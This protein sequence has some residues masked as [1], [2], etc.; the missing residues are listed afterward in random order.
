MKLPALSRASLKFQPTKKYNLLSP[1]SF[2]KWRGN[3]WPGPRSSPPT[4]VTIW[5]LLSWPFHG[6]V[7]CHATWAAQ[8]KEGLPPRP[9]IIFLSFAFFFLTVFYLRCPRFMEPEFGPSKWSLLSVLRV[10]IRQFVSFNPSESWLNYPKSFSRFGSASRGQ[11]V[12]D[13][14]FL[15]THFCAERRYEGGRF[16]CEEDF[17]RKLRHVLGWC[18][19]A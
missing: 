13:L 9:R 2:P 8:I 12:W 7:F 5:W 15:Y 19:Q 17:K 14:R 1:D 11:R 3:F 16:L 6:T 10:Q 18:C 4:K